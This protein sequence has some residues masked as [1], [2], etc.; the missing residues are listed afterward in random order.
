MEIV[1]LLGDH[2]KLGSVNFQVK[3]NILKHRAQPICILPTN[4]VAVT[5]MQAFS[6]LKNLTKL[7][8]FIAFIF[9]ISYKMTIIWQQQE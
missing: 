6:T 4:E 2:E 8:E 1:G 5:I 3:D 7:E 9:Q